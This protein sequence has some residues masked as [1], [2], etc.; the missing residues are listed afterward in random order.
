MTS[1]ATQ[2]LIVASGWQ[3][4]R[5][6]IVTNWLRLLLGI[7]G[8]LEL[9]MAVSAGPAITV[10]LGVVAGCSLLAAAILSR[11]GRRM[12][13]AVLVGVSLPFAAVTWWTIVT[14]LLTAVALAIAVAATAVVRRH[15]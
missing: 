1:T 11:P 12:L 14:P 9:M 2:H 15:A 3:R 7:L 6:I 13:I 4:F 10:A 5:T 8:A